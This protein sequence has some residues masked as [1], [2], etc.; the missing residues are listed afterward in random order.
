MTNWN[1]VAAGFAAL[2]GLFGYTA[3]QAEESWYPSRYGA[4][5]EIGAANLLSPALVREAAKLVRTGKTYALGIE[6]NSDMPA[7]APRSFKI[8]IV[9]PDQ[10]GGGTLGPNKMTY[11]DDILEG[12]LG[13]GSQIDGLGHLGIDNVYYNGYHAK[14]FA[15]PTGL[16][17]L[18]IEKIPPIV[19]RGVLIDMAAHFG[20]ARL[21][22]GAVFNS[23][24]I[25]AAAKKQG[26]E[27]RQGNVVLFH[28]GWLST[29]GEDKALFASGEP[30]LGRDGARYLASL[31]V[32]AVGA[33]TNALEPVPHEDGAGNFEVHQ[34]LLTKNGIYIF[35]NMNTAELAADKAYEFLF[36]LGQARVTGAVQMI[37]NPVAIR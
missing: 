11:N 33:D 19:T 1:F 32:V 15:K 6:S 28:T 36:V 18:G 26:V 30:G 27:I 12:W 21:E 31:G 22:K 17:K 23:A 16:T 9:Q 20:T 29:L 3:A 13:V 10:Q 34:I 37:I 14:D 8:I 4:G 2:F 35:E 7:Y 24:D 25:K 5:D